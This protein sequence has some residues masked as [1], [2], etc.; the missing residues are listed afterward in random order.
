MRLIDADERI[1]EVKR[2]PMDPKLK[3]CVLDVLRRAPTVSAAPENKAHWRPAT[4]PPELHGNFSAAVIVTDG[5]LVGGGTYFD[6]NQFSNSAWD[7]WG[8]GA[9]K[10]WMPYPDPA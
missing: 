7:W 1:E 3:D 6:V 10:A 9:P 4:D 8:S 2:S 5:L